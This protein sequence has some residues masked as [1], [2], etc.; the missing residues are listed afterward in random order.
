MEKTID[1]PRKKRATA[2]TIILTTSCSLSNLYKLSL[3]IQSRPKNIKIRYHQ[4]TTLYY[5]NQ[6]LIAIEQIYT[7]QHGRAQPYYPKRQ[8]DT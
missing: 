8:D 7:D 6:L 4:P 1:P 3:V 2:L 5:F